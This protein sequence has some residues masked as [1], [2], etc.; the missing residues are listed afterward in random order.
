MHAHRDH[1]E[2][3]EAEILQGLAHNVRHFAAGIFAEH[4]V[5]H[6]KL[7]PIRVE[8]GRSPRNG[9]KAHRHFGSRHS[10]PR[11]DELIPT[12]TQMADPRP[13][14][15]AVGSSGT[16][17]TSAFRAKSPE[18][19]FLKRSSL[20]D[21]G[22]RSIYRDDPRISAGADRIDCLKSSP[23][24]ARRKGSRHRLDGIGAN[25]RLTFDGDASRLGRGRNAESHGCGSGAHRHDPR[26]RDRGRR[27]RRRVGI[28]C[29][30]AAG[31]GGA[32]RCGG[33][34][35][36]LGRGCRRRDLER[37]PRAPLRTGERGHHFA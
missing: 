17:A 20:E 31:R 19:R 11:G 36:D 21:A 34:L 9:G 7:N 28:A 13:A 18:L 30:S 3:I 27:R 29:G 5:R 2:C 26:P 6:G 14:G 23:A 32:Q 22:L 35:V 24:Y 16:R 15:V 25:G 37:R 4:G 1:A 33:T 10:L 12:L 8:R